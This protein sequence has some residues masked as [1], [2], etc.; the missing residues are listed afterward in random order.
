VG[1][2][3]LQQSTSADPASD[4]QTCQAEGCVCEH[5]PPTSDTPADWLMAGRMVRLWSL[6]IELPL[7]AVR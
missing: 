1:G 4:D 6:H 3:V 7:T 2:S 5:Y